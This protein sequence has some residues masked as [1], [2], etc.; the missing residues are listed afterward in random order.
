MLKTQHT[1]NNRIMGFLFRSVL[2]LCLFFH[3]LFFAHTGSVSKET[4]Q[5]PPQ[6]F[7]SGS[8]NITISNGASI[9]VSNENL[10]KQSNLGEKFSVD[11]GTI[12]VS[13]GAI[14]VQGNL[15]SNLSVV[16][17]DNSKK[18]LSENQSQPLLAKATPKTVAPKQEIKETD[19]FTPTNSPNSFATTTLVVRAMINN[20]NVITVALQSNHYSENK[21]I[22]SFV[23]NSILYKTPFISSISSGGQ[24]FVRPP[25]ISYYS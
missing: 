6:T 19:K 12:Y 4:D 9:I 15:H 11:K 5:N 21:N 18:R 22:S 25:T 2:F 16:Q 24:Y 14:V 17:V 1:N 13:G 3:S 20:T 7:V 8:E 23:R 10:N